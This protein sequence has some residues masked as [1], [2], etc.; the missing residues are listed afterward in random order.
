MKLKEAIS[1]LEKNK[2]C[3]LFYSEIIEYI[4]SVREGDPEVIIELDTISLIT[5]EIDSLIKY[6][7]THRKQ[8]FNNVKS[9]QNLEIKNAVKTSSRTR[10]RKNRARSN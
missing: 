6:L 2:A 4:I 10:T 9:L 1:E 7:D 8:C 3:E 5:K